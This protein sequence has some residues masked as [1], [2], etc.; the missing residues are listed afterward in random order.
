MTLVKTNGKKINKGSKRIIDAI[1]PNQK[2]IQVGQLKGFFS[3]LL[4]NFVIM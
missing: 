3:F 4:G 2:D 1:N